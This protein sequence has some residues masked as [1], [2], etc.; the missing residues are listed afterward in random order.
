MADY[1]DQIVTLLTGEVFIQM[2]NGQ[3]TRFGLWDE[4]RGS[5]PG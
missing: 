3:V 5:E 4:L 1:I 2:Q